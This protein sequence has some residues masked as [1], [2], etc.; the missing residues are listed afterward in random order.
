MNLR[1]FHYLPRTAVEGPGLRA[2]VQVQGCPIRCPGCALPQTWPSEGGEI[3]DSAALARRI[4]ATPGLEGVT[5]LGGEPFAQAAALADVGERVRRRGLSV[6]TFTGYTLEA[7][8][9]RRDEAVDALLAVTD[10]LLAGPFRQ[11]ERDFSRPWVGSANQRFHFLTPRY[12][13]L[14]GRLAAIP[15]RIEVR[16]HPDGR[17]EMNGLAAPEAMRG[18]A[19]FSF[20]MPTNSNQNEVTKCQEKSS[21]TLPFS[22]SPAAEK[23]VC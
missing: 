22:V 16:L 2:S 11:N 14:A 6:L 15:N 20:I 9:A 12:A 10:L 17:V 3:V 21:S 8:Q 13:H 23:P 19:D 18:L 5:F 1:L 7:L 4:L